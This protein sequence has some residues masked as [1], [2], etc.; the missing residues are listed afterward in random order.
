MRSQMRI[1]ARVPA[2]LYAE[3]RARL[4]DEGEVSQSDLVRLLLQRYFTLLEVGRA[5]ARRSLSGEEVALIAD[6]MN[7]TWAADP[8]WVRLRLL[9][10]EVQDALRDADLAE[11][12]GVDG[13]ELLT[14]LQALDAA[15]HLAVL[16]SV[17]RFWVAVGRGEQP[18]PRRILEDPPRRLAGE[19]AGDGPAEDAD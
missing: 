18:D 15:E 7:G 9:A 4:R 1:N 19:D 17:E 2:E 10:A 8:T 12:W 16:D 11:K 6:V 3:V 5:G 14:K 13:A